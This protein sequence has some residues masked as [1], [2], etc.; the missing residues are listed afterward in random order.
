MFYIEVCD[1]NF[2]KII[3]R[4]GQTTV[5]PFAK[6]FILLIEVVGRK[7]YIN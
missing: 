4:V 3:P 5:D 2:I 1:L 6:T 7:L